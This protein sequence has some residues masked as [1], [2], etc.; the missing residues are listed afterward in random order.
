MHRQASFQPKLSS[1][2]QAFQ[3]TVKLESQNGK[4]VYASADINDI[5]SGW[6]HPKVMLR[7]NGTDPSAQLTMYINGAADISLRMVSLWPAEN[8][9]GEVLQPFRPDLLQYLKGLKPRCAHLLSL[10]SWSHMS[11]HL[12][13]IKALT[14]SVFDPLTRSHATGIA[15][16][17]CMAMR[18]QY[19]LCFCAMYRTLLCMQRVLLSCKGQVV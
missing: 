9:K 8:V 10:L 18:C 14:P 3:V 5:S 2:M 15:G 6:K 13:G 11:V 16:C 17:T 7:S 12:H 19:H 4:T 1:S